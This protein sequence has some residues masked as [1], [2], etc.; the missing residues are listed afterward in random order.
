MRF[1]NHRGHLILLPVLV[2]AINQKSGNI[3]DGSNGDVAADH[4]HRY[5]VSII[6]NIKTFLSVLMHSS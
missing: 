2:L 5:K 1:E 3:E 6:R 4:Y